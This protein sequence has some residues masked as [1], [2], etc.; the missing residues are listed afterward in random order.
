ML[1]RFIPT[2]TVPRFTRRTK[3]NAYKGK[4]D[5]GLRA[6]RSSPEDMMLQLWGKHQFSTA[7]LNLTEATA[8]RD[9]LNEIISELRG[10]Q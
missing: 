10:C 8:L 6:Y 7:A 5:Q 2:P 1:P 9:K 3:D 4:E